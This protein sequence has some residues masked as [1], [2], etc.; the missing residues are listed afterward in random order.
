MS[1]LRFL[2][3]KKRSSEKRKFCQSYLGS[4]ILFLKS[5]VSGGAGTRNRAELA[6]RQVIDA[7]L[8]S[9]NC[10]KLSDNIVGD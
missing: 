1:K 2:S 4:G 9:G 7:L 5:C 6:V 3:L 10:M 8:Q